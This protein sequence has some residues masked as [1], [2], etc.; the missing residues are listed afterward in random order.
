M[1]SPVRIGVI[2]CGSVLQD[3]YLPIANDLQAHGL[4]EVRIA[5]DTNPERALLTQQLGIPAFTTDYRTVVAANDVDL[6][7]VLTPPAFH[8][9]IAAAA[10]QAGN[11]SITRR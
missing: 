11:H 1:P 8:A 4:T 9:P 7:L 10:L 5:C 2:G 3:G 6:V